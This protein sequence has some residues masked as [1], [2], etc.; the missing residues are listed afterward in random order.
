MV[1]D[2]SQHPTRFRLVAANCLSE[3]QLNQVDHHHPSRPQHVNEGRWVVVKINDNRR[4]LMRITV[5]T[6]EP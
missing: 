6:A 4:P 2:Q 3:L 1:R 5:G